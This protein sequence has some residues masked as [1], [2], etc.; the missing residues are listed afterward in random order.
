MTL[1]EEGDYFETDVSPYEQYRSMIDQEAY[2]LLSEQMKGF[3]RFQP[4]SHYVKSGE[5][6]RLVKM[7]FT[8]GQKLDQSPL[9]IHL[10]VRLLD[11]VFNLLGGNP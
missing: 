11:R 2:Q 1:K 5:R 9:T 8:I 10:A 7:I 3:S 6:K 4:L